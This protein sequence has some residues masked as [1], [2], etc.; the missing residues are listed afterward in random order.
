LAQ[1]KPAGVLCEKAKVAQERFDGFD[2]V[3]GHV[4]NFLAPIRG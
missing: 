3:G 1:R 2:E 4:F